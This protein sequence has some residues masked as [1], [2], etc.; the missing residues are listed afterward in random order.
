MLIGAEITLDG[1]IEEAFEWFDEI[2]SRCKPHK[3]WWDSKNNRPV[4]A[5]IY[6]KIE[7]ID[8]HW[9]LLDSGVYDI[10]KCC[11]TKAKN[12][13]SFKFIGTNWTS[14]ELK[15]EVTKQYK[16]FVELDKQRKLTEDFE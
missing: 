4:I 2:K 7:C 14:D 16:Q 12:R 13:Y 3:G 8:G 9:Y 1:L 5:G 15:T 6:V 11:Y 10:G